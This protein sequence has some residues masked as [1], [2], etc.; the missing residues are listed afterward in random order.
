MIRTAPSNSGTT[1]AGSFR[2]GPWF[3]RQLT[4]NNSEYFDASKMARIR[5]NRSPLVNDTWIQHF[6]EHQGFTGN[7]A[8]HHHID[9]GPIA[10]PIPETVHHSWYKALHPNQYE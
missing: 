10:T 4:N 9:Q 5:T 3:W 7:R 2:N 8:V 6:P 1:A